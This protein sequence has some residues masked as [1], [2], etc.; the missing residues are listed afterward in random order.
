MN[1]TPEWTTPVRAAS[2]S[3]KRTL[4]ALSPS[5]HALYSL[6]DAT[7]LAQLRR[8]IRRHETDKLTRG[9]PTVTE[10]GQKAVKSLAGVCA[11]STTTKRRRRTRL[12]TVRSPRKRPEN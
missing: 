12:F 8:L 7:L 11:Y 3:A 2:S 4:T 6:N 9:Y 10:S 1:R 5:H